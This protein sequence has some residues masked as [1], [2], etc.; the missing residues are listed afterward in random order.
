MPDR[1]GTVGSP[2]PAEPTLKRKRPRTTMK[3]ILAARA[4]AKAK[5]HPK[6]PKPPRVP[7][8]KK[9]KLIQINLG[10]RHSFNGVFIG[11]GLVT[12][13]EAKARRLLSTEH[14]AMSKEIELTQNRAFIMSFRNGVPV[15]REVPASR[16]DDILAR[17][18]LP[19]G[20]MGGER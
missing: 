16:F 20:T 4:A 10:M 1:N 17:E 14:D 6:P 3:S 18:E 13:T 5:L 12:T 19:V 11:P 8:P 15:R 7:A 9:E 2:S